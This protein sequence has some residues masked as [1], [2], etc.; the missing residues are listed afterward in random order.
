MYLV[1]YKLFENKGRHCLQLWKKY[2][3]TTHYFTI[4]LIHH[5]RGTRIRTGITCKKIP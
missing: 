5:K 1:Y 2:N 4:D 3:E